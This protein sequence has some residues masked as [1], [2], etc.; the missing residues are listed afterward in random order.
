MAKKAGPRKAANQKPVTESAEARA[1]DKERHI[2]EAAVRVFARK[3]FHAARVSDIAREAGVAY[4]LVYHYFTNKDEILSSIF[5]RNWSVVVK[6]MESMEEQQQTFRARVTAIVEFMMN[7]YKLS[8]DTVDL[9]VL[10]FG[11]SSRLAATVRQ[12]TVDRS[13]AVL[14]RIMEAG[15]KS[16]E[17]RDDLDPRVM[18]TLFLG[19]IETGL[20]AFVTRLIN[21]DEALIDQ[22]KQAVVATFLDGVSP[23]TRPQRGAVAEGRSS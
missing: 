15:Q 7:V 5:Q 2:L 8:P 13:W 20:A 11:R 22:M 6:M 14:Q 4:G 21:Q 9:L 18:T 10:E 12:P 19:L 23:R 1:R 16:G 3:G 17:A